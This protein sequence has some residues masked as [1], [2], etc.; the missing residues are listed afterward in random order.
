MNVLLHLRYSRSVMP[1]CRGVGESRVYS[2]LTKISP[3]A[4]F[5]PRS[6]I[7]VVGDYEC[8]VVLVCIEFNFSIGLSTQ[9]IVGRGSIGAQG[10]INRWNAWVRWFRNTVVASRGLGRRASIGL[11][12][13]GAQESIGGKESSS[14]GRQGGKSPVPRVYVNQS[15]PPSPDASTRLRCTNYAVTLELSDQIGGGGGKWQ[16]YLAWCIT[17]SRSLLTISFLSFAF[18]DWA[19][20]T[21]LMHSITHGTT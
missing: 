11:Q 15:Y 2:K 5:A 7:T 3:S 13:I 8:D 1:D 4:G 21:T 17:P 18:I 14:W 10:I 9:R 12:S 6:G 16:A 20:Y 19:H